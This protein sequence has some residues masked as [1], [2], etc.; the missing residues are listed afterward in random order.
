MLS[1]ILSIGQN[2]TEDQLD[3]VL[4]IYQAYRG[5]QTPSREVHAH[6][7]YHVAQASQAKH[8]SL[9]DR[10]ANG[11]LAGSNVRALS[12]S[13]RKCTVT[14]IDNHELPGLMLCNMLHLL[15]PI[16]SL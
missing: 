11:G 5:R 7:T 9:V 15:T 4:Q 13:P 1:L 6:I 3:Q 16:M 14:G 10:G 2:H 12:T 8:V